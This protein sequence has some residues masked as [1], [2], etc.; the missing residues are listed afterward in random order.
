MPPITP[1]IGLYSCILL[2][3]N[4]YKKYDNA[5]IN[6]SANTTPNPDTK[7]EIRGR[8]SALCMHSTATGPTVMDAEMPTVAPSHISENI[9]QSNKLFFKECFKNP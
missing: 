1:S 7:D 2:N 5:A 3:I 6:V 8:V 9:S 4:E